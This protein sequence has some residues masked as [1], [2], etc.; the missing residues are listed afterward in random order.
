VRKKYRQYS[1]EFKL[2][3]IQRFLAGEARISDL[4]AEA[5]VQRSLFYFW[6]R[7]Y[8]RGELAA[9]APSGTALAEAEAR[10][11]ALERKVGQLTME[12]ELARSGILAFPAAGNVRPVGAPAPRKYMDDVAA[13]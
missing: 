9:E 8:E 13:S 10:I 5:G 6:L 2:G 7:K 3:L 11:A 1:N 12:L 4:A